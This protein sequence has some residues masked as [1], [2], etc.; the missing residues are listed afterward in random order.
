MQVDLDTFQ[1][2]VAELLA[3]PSLPDLED[4]YSQ[5]ADVDPYPE[6]PAALLHAGHI[7]SYVTTVG[8]IDPFDARHLTKPA[9]YLVPLE[10]LV[11]YV[12]QQGNEQRFFLSKDPHPEESD[13]RSHVIVE[14]NAV[15]YVTLRPTFRFPAYIAARFIS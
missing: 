3:Y 6:I 15:C 11:R 2:K 8:I 9:T 5:L 7:A 1:R 10:G 13:V 12:D 4:R 14:S